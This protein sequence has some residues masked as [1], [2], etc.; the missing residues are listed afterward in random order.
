MKETKKSINFYYICYT[1]NVSLNKIFD[2]QIN[3]MQGRNESNLLLFKWESSPKVEKQNFLKALT[4]GWSTLK[5]ASWHGLLRRF[6]KQI[7]ASEGSIF[8]NKTAARKDIPWTWKAEKGSSWKSTN[9]KLTTLMY[10]DHFYK[11]VFLYWK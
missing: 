11:C 8:S 10:S 5:N 6:A 3:Q 2:P 1:S 4:I 7:N 9:L